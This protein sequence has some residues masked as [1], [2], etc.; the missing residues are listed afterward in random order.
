MRSNGQA[1]QSKTRREFNAFALSCREITVAFNKHASCSTRKSERVLFTDSVRFT[2]RLRFE[3][4]F[5]A[6]AGRA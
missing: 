6:A 4:L 3:Q 1:F 2:A 5:E